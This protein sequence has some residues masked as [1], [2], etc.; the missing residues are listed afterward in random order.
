MKLVGFIFQ[1][2]SSDESF[3]ML[4]KKTSGK[5][6]KKKVDPWWLEDDEEDKKIGTGTTVFVIS[7]TVNALQN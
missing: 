4:Q 6:K 1:S 5:S 2:V 3:D 7:C